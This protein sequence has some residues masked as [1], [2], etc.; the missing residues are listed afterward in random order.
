MMTKAK[1]YDG[2]L[3]GSGKEEEQ[4]REVACFISKTNIGSHFILLN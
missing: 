3:K 1:K 4:H 2:S